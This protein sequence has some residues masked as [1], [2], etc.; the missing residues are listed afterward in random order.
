MVRARGA[1]TT[2][3]QELMRRAVA[4][5]DST[6]VDVL[7]DRL[8]GIAAVQAFLQRKQVTGIRVDR[9]ERTLQAES[10]GL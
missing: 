8:G 6:A 7:I 3:I 4:D 9:H 2:T 1:L 5:S 10:V